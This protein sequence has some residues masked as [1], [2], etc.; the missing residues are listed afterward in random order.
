MN[1]YK[2]HLN[3]ESQQKTEYIKRYMKIIELKNTIK[4]IIIKISGQV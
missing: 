4:N 2:F 1:K 3:K